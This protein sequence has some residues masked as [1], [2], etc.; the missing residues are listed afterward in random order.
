M[1]QWLEENDESPE[2]IEDIK[3]GFRVSTSRQYEIA[4]KSLGRFLRDLPPQKVTEQLLRRFFNYL[5]QVKKLA[6]STIAA[7]KSALA[8]P[9]FLAFGLDLQKR[10]FGLQKRSFLFKRPTPVKRPPVW[11]A[12]KVVAFLLS[13]DFQGTPANRLKKVLFLIALATGMRTNELA[14]L[15]RCPSLLSFHDRDS[16]VEFFPHSRLSAKK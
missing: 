1:A 12:H 14:S 16:A 8:D 2:V 5:S 4:W 9:L 15:K 6:T 13:E 11:S 3:N 10:L 7:Y